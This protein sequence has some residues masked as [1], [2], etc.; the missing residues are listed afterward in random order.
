LFGTKSDWRSF[1]HFPQALAYHL[2][3]PPA[4]GKQ[5]LITEEISQTLLTNKKQ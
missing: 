4:N 2:Q 3:N 1:C 5:G